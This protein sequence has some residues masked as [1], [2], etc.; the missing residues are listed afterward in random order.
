MPESDLDAVK[1][2]LVGRKR[3]IGLVSPVLEEAE[4]ALKKAGFTYTV[5]IRNE[6]C[7]MVQMECELWTERRKDKG[8]ILTSSCPVIVEM[9]HS[10]YPQICSYLSDTPS[11]MVL[12]AEKI[13]K[14]E[15]DSILV[16]IG[17]CYEKK[18]EKRIAHEGTAVDYTLLPRALENL[19]EECGVRGI[20]K[21]CW[22]ASKK[23][24]ELGGV[25]GII[26]VMNSVMP[27]GDRGCPRYASY[28]GVD[29][30][31]SFLEEVM[32]GEHLGEYVEL[33]ACKGGCYGRLENS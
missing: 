20:L 14:R 2:L 1:R 7:E 23:S 8:L 18:R 9:I 4:N 26:A 28:A 16:F 21:D 15:P 25:G 33:S 29:E 12:A 32:K 22:Q 30:C 3:V 13:R 31:R 5:K 6:A 17:P 11:P 19:L 10:Q 27:E 24:N